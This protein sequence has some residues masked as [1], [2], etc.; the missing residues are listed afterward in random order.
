MKIEGTILNIQ[1]AKIKIIGEDY[2][3]LSRQPTYKIKVLS[4]ELEGQIIQRKQSLID[5][6]LD[7]LQ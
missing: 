7:E 6:Y 4:C 2:C 3:P 5:P 1:G